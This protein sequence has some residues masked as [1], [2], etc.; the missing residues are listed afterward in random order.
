[1]SGFPPL[2]D[3]RSRIL[4]LGSFPSVKSL[5]NQRYY[6][7]PLN[8][9]WDLV[10]LS[11]GTSKPDLADFGAAQEWL[12]DLGLAI[13]DTIGTCVRPGSL[14]QNIRL[15][16]ANDI[17]ALL[18]RWPKIRR[19]LLNGGAAAG[20][21]TKL[22]AP[23]LLPPLPEVWKLPSSSPIPSRNYRKLEDKLPVWKSALLGNK[24]LTG[25]VV[26]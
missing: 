9:F 17:A 18:R 12:L 11:F 4:I 23:T 2:A 19:I 3:G 24:D 1:M 15:A 22:I 25:P 6:G 10:A 14:D 5:A 7:N 20:Y 21:F 16:Q 13:W 8:H 26:Q